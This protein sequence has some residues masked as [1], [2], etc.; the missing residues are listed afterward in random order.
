MISLKLKISYRSDY[1]ELSMC[2]HVILSGEWLNFMVLF[3]SAKMTTFR[4]YSF[5][6]PNTTK[7]FIIGPFDSWIGDVEFSLANGSRRTQNSLRDDSSIDTTRRHIS[8]YRLLSFFSFGLSRWR[9]FLAPLQTFF[10]CFSSDEY[11]F[12]VS[13]QGFPRTIGFC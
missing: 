1:W 2:W 6:D 10:F 13:L 7:A 12:R 3:E 9:I 4:N 5:S 11:W 8:R